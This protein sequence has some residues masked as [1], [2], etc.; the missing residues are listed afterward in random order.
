[1]NTEYKLSGKSGNIFIVGILLG[2]ILVTLLSIICAYIDVYNPIVYL[3]L[4]VFI[5]L[6]FGIII[7]QKLVIRLSKCRSKG[8]SIVYGIV[9]GLFGVYASWCTF[10]YVIFRK[11]D[12]PVELLNLMLNPSLVFE[13]AQ[14]L[15]VDGYYTLFGATVKGGVLWFI[16][17]VE[18]IGIIGAGALGGLAVMHEEIFCEECNRW[19]EDIDFNLRLAL[20]DK[21]LAKKTIESDITKLLDYPLYTG[22]NSEHIKINLHQCSKCHIT[23]TIDVDFMSYET[24]DKGETKEKNEDFSKVYILNLNQ[25]KQFIDKKPTHNSVQAP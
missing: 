9:T 25:I 10:L 7:V 18:V 22:T 20:E 24:N 11:E 23:S 4:L 3:T 19:A 6:L 14:S 21:D 8:S 2:P 15:S 16:W 12:L 5:G 1:M 13:M 17:I